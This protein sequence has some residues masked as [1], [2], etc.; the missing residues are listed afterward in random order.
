MLYDMGRTGALPKSFAKL[1]RHSAP[2]VGLVVT[3]AL[4]LGA[5]LF[6]AYRS[7]DALFSLM[8]SFACI[9]YALV[10]AAAIKD[11][12]RGKG[13]KSFF[14]DKAIPIL[15][16]GIML[17]MLSSMSPG[18]LLTVGAWA[19]LG[20]LIVFSLKARRGRDFFKQVEL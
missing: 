19:L 6:G 1:N 13:L 11:R 15:A 18:Y 5:A 12:W 20:A 14:I 7:V 4:W 10:C 3:M 17:W 8:S 16:I 9:A 2:S